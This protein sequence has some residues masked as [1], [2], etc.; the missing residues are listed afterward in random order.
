[1]APS[2]TEGAIDRQ[3]DKVHFG[4]KLIHGSARQLKNNRKVEDKQGEASNDHQVAE[5]HADAASSSSS[6]KKIDEANQVDY[7]G[8]VMNPDQQPPSPFPPFPPSIPGIPGLPVPY[9][10]PVPVPTTPIPIPV[11]TIPIPPLPPIP[12][13]PGFPVPPPPV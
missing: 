5:N 3:E 7:G 6:E 8:D 13:I 12:G 1:M 11:P 4:V 9:P 2:N 10:V